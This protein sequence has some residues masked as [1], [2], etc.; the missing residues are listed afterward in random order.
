LEGDYEAAQTGH[1]T[2]ADYL[3]VVRRHRW[4]IIF[5]GIVVALAV[6]LFTARQVKPYEASSQVIELGASSPTGLN[7]TEIDRRAQTDA[8]LARTPSLAAKVLQATG[9]KGSTDDFLSHSSVQAAANSD[10]LTFSVKDANPALA[11]NLAN[12]YAR[13]FARYRTEVGQAAFTRAKE[14]LDADIQTTE[15]QL[16]QAKA[17]AKG[18]PSPTVAVLSQR[19]ASLLDE[20]QRLETTQA[21]DSSNLVVVPATR[22]VRGGRHLARNTILGLTFGLLLGTILSFVRE[23]LDPRI[24]TAE[25]VSEELGLPLLGRI[26]SSRQS[27]R[28]GTLAMLEQPRSPMAEPY[29]ILRTNVEFANRPF[30]AST[31]MIVGAAADDDR[32]AIVGNLGVSFART[33]RRVMVIDLDLREPSLDDLFGLP[34][35]PG[36]TDLAMKRARLTQTLA[37]VELQD[38]SAD[39]SEAGGWSGKGTLTVVR[40]G[41]KPPDP[42]DFVGMQPLGDVLDQLAGRSDLVLIDSPPILD[43]SD[44]VALSANVDAIIVAIKLG[45][46]T[47]QDGD[48]LRRVLDVCPAPK[49]G[50]IITGGDGSRSPEPKAAPAPPRRAEPSE[51][52]ESRDPEASDVT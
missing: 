9:T 10:V 38:P 4:F 2:F 16:E 40:A 45:A 26:P 14:S 43:Y 51:P 8:S 34:E 33:G 48:E 27:A 5:T 13:G 17:A 46:L 29:R 39:D 7:S 19:Y 35:G 22:A 42:G 28:R 47:R 49:L 18:E 36:I 41:T 20:E 32:A 52:S 12:S 24:R 44:A 25:E 1:V 3:D 15:A 30:G 11:V 37:K 23:A 21:V 50:Y 31:I 6:A